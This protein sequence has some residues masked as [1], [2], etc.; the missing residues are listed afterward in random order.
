MSKRSRRSYRYRRTSQPPPLVGARL[1]LATRHTGSVQAFGVRDFKLRVQLVKGR[2]RH[3]DKTRCNSRM[4]VEF[5]VSHHASS[6]HRKAQPFNCAANL[7]TSNESHR[8]A[9]QSCVMNDAKTWNTDRVRARAEGRSVFHL[10]ARIIRPNRRCGSRPSSNPYTGRR[11]CSH[12][13]W[14]PTPCP[15]P[16]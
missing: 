12:P 5:F 2:Q 7:V 6:V 1:A 14:D 8:D 3:A 16:S 11:A 15:C 13:S 9:A 10:S 4:V